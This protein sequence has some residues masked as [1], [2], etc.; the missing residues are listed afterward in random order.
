MW[1]PVRLQASE[2]PP[3]LSTRIPTQRAS[4]DPWRRQVVCCLELAINASQ[5]TNGNAT[6]V[7]PIVPILYDPTGTYTCGSTNGVPGMHSTRASTRSKWIVAVGGHHR[8]DAIKTPTSRSC[9][10]EPSLM[11]ALEGAAITVLAKGVKFPAGIER[12][13]LG[14]SRGQYAGRH[15]ASYDRRLRF[16]GGGGNGG[17]WRVTVLSS[18]IPYPEQLLAQPST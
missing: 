15:H 8:L 1:K 4:W 13:D 18:P 14:R 5:T 16:R 11:G 10:Q 7:P 2:V 9:L 6:N 17:G 12:S 3:A